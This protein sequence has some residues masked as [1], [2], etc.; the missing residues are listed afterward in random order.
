M[1]LL[2]EIITL[3]L[4]FIVYQIYDLNK[5]I[6]VVIIAYTLITLA[7][8][9]KHKRLSKAQMATFVLVVLLGGATLLF[10]NELFFKWKPTVV[11]WL[12]SS[13]LLGSTLFTKQNLLQRLGNGNI[14]L[15]THIWSRLNIA[16]ITFL[17]MMG[18][19]NLFVAYNFDTTVWVYFKL[20]G[21]VG[22]LLTFMIVQCIF[23][24]PYIR[25]EGKEE[26]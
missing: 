15:P 3:V 14:Q 26:R 5:A 4:F 8:F 24:W 11:C 23:L 10:D 22:L 18:A 6:L 7:A 20:F 2:F 1:K 9:I 16:W 17:A 13:V 12:F 21:A 25:A 19:I